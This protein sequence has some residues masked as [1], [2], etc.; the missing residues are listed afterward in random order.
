MADEITNQVHSD[1]RR[2]EKEELI[3]PHLEESPEATVKTTGAVGHEDAAGPG[4]GGRFHRLRDPRIR[5]TGRPLRGSRS[6]G[7]G[8]VYILLSIFFIIAAGTLLS[9]GMIPVDPVGSKGPP[10]LAPYFNVGGEFDEQEIIFPSKGPDAKENLQL[11]TFK[12]N[13]CGQTTAID[14][15]VDTSA[16]MEDDNKMEK[17]K[18]AL[19]SFVGK[20]SNSS[21]IAIHTFSAITEEHV[22]FDYY[23]NN[24][25]QVL[26]TIEG[27]GPEGWTSTR[28]GFQ[29][30]KQ[31]ISNA[32]TK[33]RFPGYTYN[34]VLL[35]DGVPEIPQYPDEP[36]RQCEAEVP[37]AL[38]PGGIRCFS[39]DQDPRIPTNLA[40]DIK[41]LGAT[42]FSVGIYSQT[43]SDNQMKPYLEALLK[44]VASAPSSEYYFSSIEG[45]NLN[46]ILKSII[47]TTC[48][49]LEDERLD[50]S[51]TIP[52]VENPVSPSTTIN[53]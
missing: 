39:T 30:A 49:G 41:N 2:D 21:V 35:T 7:V 14:F 8:Y 27:L 46:T 4:V 51:P 28:D 11:K 13:V 16:S 29:L 32:V 43:S 34:L 26:A 36:P 31:T 37:D 1:K 18:A 23:K 50:L 25:Q 10:T 20:L 9:G 38:E 24:K 19:R 44:D 42:I 33:K 45:D 6:P 48:Q 5:I 15:L 47:S 40:Q 3:D 17:L 52:P 22:P 53:Q 12:V